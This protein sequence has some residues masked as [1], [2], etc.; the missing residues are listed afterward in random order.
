MFF[1]FFLITAIGKETKT[2]VE[3]QTSLLTAKNQTYRWRT[4]LESIT[5][6]TRGLAPVVHEDRWPYRV[7]RP[8]VLLQ[9]E[10]S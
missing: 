4:N 5:V 3:T 7:G 2:A 6:S 8:C 1:F 10:L 9:W